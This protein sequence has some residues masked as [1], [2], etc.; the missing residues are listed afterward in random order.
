VN[1][2]LPVAVTDRAAL[3][4]AGPFSILLNSD[5]LEIAAV[6]I[7]KDMLVSFFVTKGK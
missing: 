7:C 6:Y 5:S 3:I 2:T 1:V 4:L